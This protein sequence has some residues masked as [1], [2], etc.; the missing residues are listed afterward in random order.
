MRTSLL[1]L[2]ALP[3]LAACVDFGRGPELDDLVGQ[4]LQAEELD[5][6]ELTDCGGVNEGACEEDGTEYDAS[7]ECIDDAFATCTPAIFE[8]YAENGDGLQTRT[9]LVVHPEGDGCAVERFVDAP[10]GTRR[11]LSQHACESL[12]IVTDACMEPDVSECET[13]CEGFEKDQCWWPN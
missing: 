1:S 12:S 6:A 8:F 4:F 11:E 3:L 9:V 10:D 5:R 7:V 13:V 2:L